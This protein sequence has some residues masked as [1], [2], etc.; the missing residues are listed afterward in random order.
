MTKLF[1]K[2]EIEH[3]NS[4]IYVLDSAS[5]E[6]SLELELRSFP[7]KKPNELQIN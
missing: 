7:P 3:S 2:P 6:R 1:N 5:R 4:K